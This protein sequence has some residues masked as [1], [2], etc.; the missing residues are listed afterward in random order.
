MNERLVVGR[1]P[2]P[3]AVEN[4]QDRAEADGLQLAHTRS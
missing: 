3:G 4:W 2:R 1:V